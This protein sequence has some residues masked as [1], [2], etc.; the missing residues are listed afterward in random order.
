MPQKKVCYKDK[1]MIPIFINVPVL[2]HTEESSK[3]ED[4]GLEDAAEESYVVREV[5]LNIN[6]I[7]Y[8]DSPINDESRIIIMLVSGN[9]MLCAIS[10]S[11][12]AEKID[13]IISEILEE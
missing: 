9:S 2:C 1:I 8:F 5:S 3:L 7:E 4:L 10:K 12:L 11:S 13:K 6:N